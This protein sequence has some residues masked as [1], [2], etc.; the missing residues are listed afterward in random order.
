LGLSVHNLQHKE[1]M[2]EEGKR[3]ALFSHAVREDLR[4][5][6]VGRFFE[7][8][9]DVLVEGYF[10]NWNMTPPQE[11]YDFAHDMH[12]KLVALMAEER[13]LRLNR[14]YARCTAREFYENEI[15][16]TFV[17]T[18]DVTITS[19]R[20]DNMDLFKSVFDIIYR[21][22]IFANL[23][24][25]TGQLVTQARMVMLNPDKM[26]TPQLVLSTIKLHDSFVDIM[27]FAEELLNNAGKD[28]M[29]ELS[30]VDS[31]T[32]SLPPRRPQAPP[33]GGGGRKRDII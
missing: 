12:G 22:M 1:E 4:E 13:D 15:V 6:T 18:L 8:L 17:L 5:Y 16:K 29:E 21:R 32:P 11:A 33:P 27:R 26:L 20:S 30:K 14:F 19:I 24:D 31:P 10:Q 2:M 7:E 25:T 3:D 23:I 28:I 9:A